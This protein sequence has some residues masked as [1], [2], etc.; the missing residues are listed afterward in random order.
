MKKKAREFLPFAGEKRQ[1]KE[2]LDGCRRRFGCQA[3][4]S[5]LHF[6]PGQYTMRKRLE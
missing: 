1:K 4:I 3:A 5:H 2:N 6:H